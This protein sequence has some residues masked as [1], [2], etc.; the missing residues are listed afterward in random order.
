MAQRLIL[1]LSGESFDKAQWLP[2]G[3]D[4]RADG[5]IGAGSLADAALLRRPAIV[6]APTADVALFHVQIPPLSRQRAIR[7]VPYALEDQ[8]AE[9]I[10]DLHFCLGQRSGQGQ[11]AVAVVAKAQMEQWLNAFAD[12][13]LEVEQLYPELLAVPYEPGAWTLLLEGSDFLLRTG[14]QSGFGGDIDNLPVLLPAALAEA[15]NDPPLKLIAYSNT[16]VPELGAASLPIEQRELGDTIS[17]LAAN[18]RDRQLIGLRSGPYA[19][20][21]GWSV[22]WQRWRV[23]AILLGAWVLADTG[24]ALLQQWQ[25]SRELAAVD[26]AMAQTYRQ[27]FPDGGQLNR[28]N[29]RQQMETRLAAL[30]RGGSDSGFL[31]LLQTAGPLLAADPDLQIVALTYRNNGLDLEVSAGNLQG[32]DQLKQRLSAEPGLGVEVISARAEGDRAQGKLRLEASS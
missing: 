4:G 30:R 27:A 13:G 28:Y 24:S 17:L 12:A 5:P 31:R 7:A 18:I 11:L 25:L 19:R 15:E 26:A 22:P 16:S 29:P 3:A 8:L 9:D 21:R 1:R 32:I 10:D 2:L 23:A 20:R 6:L 14:P